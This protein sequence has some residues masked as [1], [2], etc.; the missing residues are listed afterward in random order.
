VA[1]PKRYVKK[2]KEAKMSIKKIL[3][4][5]DA[6]PREVVDAPKGSGGFIQTASEPKMSDG[7]YVSRYGSKAQL[8]GLRKIIEKERASR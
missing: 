2:N 3:R 4:L 7:E 6:P 8:S 5:D 1:S